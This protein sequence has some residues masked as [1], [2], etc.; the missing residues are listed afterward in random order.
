MATEKQKA[1]NK[2]NAQHSTGPT[3]EAG[4]VESALNNWRHGMAVR[5][6]EH[7]GFLMEENPKNSRSFLA[8]FATNTTL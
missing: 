1:A 7:F 2:L 4:S 8:S 3:S 6:H 5:T